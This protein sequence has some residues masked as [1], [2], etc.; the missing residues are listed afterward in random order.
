MPMPDDT[1]AD[2]FR[3]VQRSR[4]KVLTEMDRMFAAQKSGP[5]MSDDEVAKMV[6]AEIDAARAERGADRP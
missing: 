5:A 2:P 3:R 4:Q 6:E 1:S